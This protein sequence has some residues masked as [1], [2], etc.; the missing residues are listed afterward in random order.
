MKL[1]ADFP[2]K[3]FVFLAHE[4]NGIPDPA[5]AEYVRRL[6]DI[7][8]RVQGYKAFVTTR[9]EDAEKGEGGSDFVIWEDG[10]RE[11]WIDKL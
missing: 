2:N 11:Y 3:L 8:I 10:A 9:Y 7:K 6:S 5:I 4:K 1:L